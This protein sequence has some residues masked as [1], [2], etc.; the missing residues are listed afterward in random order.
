M[1]LI[2]AGSISLDSAFK[3]IVKPK[4][5]EIDTGNIWTVSNSY[6]ITVVFWS[7]YSKGLLASIKRK[8]RFQR[9][10]PV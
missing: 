3:D 5:R 2:S 4:N 10:G 6:T 7:I 9:L 8:K 1:S